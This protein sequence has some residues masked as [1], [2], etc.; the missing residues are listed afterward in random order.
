ML[1]K[2][3]QLQDSSMQGFFSL[4]FVL[5]H[6]VSRTFRFEGILQQLMVN[7]FSLL[8][9]SFWYFR[10]GHQD[11]FDYENGFLDDCSCFWVLALW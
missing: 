2:I 7:V 6:A 10:R 4:Q 5:G 8:N 9:S 11:W 1:I 3:I